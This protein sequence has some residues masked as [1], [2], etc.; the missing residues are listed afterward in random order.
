M[1]QQPDITPYGEQFLLHVAGA[2]P[3][4]CRIDGNTQAGAPSIVF[5]NS[6]ATNL[7]MWDAQLAAFSDAYRILRYD[8]RGHGS[9]PADA[10]QEWSFDAMA[11]DVVRL[12]D[13]LGIERAILVGISMGAVTVLRCAAR[14]PQ[15]VECVIASDGQWAAPE[16]APVAWQQRI[17]KAQREGMAALAEPTL[18]RW[19]LP[20]FAARDPQARARVAAM[21][22]STSLDGYAGCA[23]AMQHYDFRADYAQLALPVLLL[24]GAQDG[25]LPA[26]MRQMQRATPG[27]QLLEIDDAGHLPNIERSEAFNAA[28]STFLQG[29]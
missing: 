5:C 19:F 7:T 13:A 10:E 26:V 21:I 4:N 20:A 23:R 1:H 27:A 29:R 11:D 28:V 18:Q 15:R 16:T 22:S 12:L 3:L 25:A 2:L 8:Q 17:G 6:H 14:F 9:T 24:V